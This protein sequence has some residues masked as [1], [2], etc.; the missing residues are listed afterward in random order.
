MEVV[1]IIILIVGLIIIT[2]LILKGIWNTHILK[3][4][5]QEG[6]VIVFGKKRK[7]KDL[8]FQIVINARKR[9][10]LAN[11]T[12]GGKYTHTE[13]KELSVAPNTYQNFIDGKITKI[14]KTHDDNIDVYIS[15]AGIHLPSQYDSI[16]HKLYPSFPIY[17]ALSGQLYN[18]N[19]HMNTQ[20][21]DRP[22]KA[23]REQAD[24]Y[25]KVHR[26]SKIGPLFIVYYTTYDKYTSAKL[27]MQP[28]GNRIFNKYSKAEQDKFKAENGNIVNRYSFLWQWKIKYDTRH[29]AK[30][31]FK[32]IDANNQI[33]E[34]DETINNEI[35]KI[36]AAK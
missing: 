9:P 36:D 11:N 12:Y 16:L 33:I 15:D 13:I 14:N 6:N 20:A 31:I 22:W 21:L 35:K 18:Q 7:G 5:F 32:N 8:L 19:I 34:V 23:I 2:Y 30:K 1:F 10:Y 17:Y 29:F 25:I 24:T 3:G 28:M 26:K 27:E 4:L